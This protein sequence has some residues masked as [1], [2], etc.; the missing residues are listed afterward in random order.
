MTTA[1]VSTDL[2][3]LRTTRGPW[4]VAAITVGLAGA[5]F[6]FIAIF[7]G[8]PGQ[9]PLEPASLAGLARAPGRITGAAAFLL[10]LL[11]A[12]SEYRHS[13]VLTSRLGHPRV[14]GLLAGKT[15]AAALT[16]LV[17]GLTVEAVMVVG[18]VFLLASRGV[19]VQPLQHGLPAAVLAAVVVVA[20]HAVMGVAVGEL[21]RNPA[22]AIGLAFGWVF[23]VEGVLPVLLREPGLVRWLPTGA[24]SAALSLGT[25]VTDGALAPTAGFA[26]LAAYTVALWL[27]GL[28]RSQLTDP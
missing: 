24:V 20:L 28:A 9:P 4:A 22:L 6:A 5:L 15:A 25:P 7:L 11:L 14:P 16:G 2:F 3:K 27:A 17:L 10:G 21:L 1:V 26:L 18:G 8:D 13:T 19:A 23:L 12:T